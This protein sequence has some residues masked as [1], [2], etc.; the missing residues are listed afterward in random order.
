MTRISNHRTSTS[1]TVRPLR[2]E[3][4]RLVEEAVEHIENGV[5]AG[6]Y[7]PG[8]R[9]VEAEVA[10]QSGL[11]IGPVREA[12]R[13]LA[14]EGLV[15][16]RPFRG[17][18]VKRMS[19][20]ELVQVY[21]ALK[22]IVYMSLT[23]AAPLC[24]N[25]TAR[26]RLTSAMNV[27]RSASRRTPLPDFLYA[28]AEYYFALHEIV[29]NAY[30]TILVKRL[31]LGLV[32][33]ELA[34]LLGGMNRDEVVEVYRRATEALLKGDAQHAIRVKF[35]YFDGLIMRIKGLESVTIDPGLPDF[36][37]DARKSPRVIPR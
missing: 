37:G 3:G 14:G 25:L 30:L 8:H 26:R 34:N 11:N 32:H 22:G 13:L 7:P 33:R 19:P 28:L 24:K 16:I 1:T 20:D 12:L 31:H 36:R 6:L 5:R 9:L 4:G 29:G 27:V 2:P 18:S 35:E 17:A 23:L 10:R 15:D 21:Q